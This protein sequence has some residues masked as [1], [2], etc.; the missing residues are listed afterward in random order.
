[1]KEDYK[2]LLALNM[3]GL[4][5]SL[6]D[7][8]ERLLRPGREFAQASFCRITTVLLLLAGIGLQGRVW[9]AFAQQESAPSF[10]VATIKPAPPF[11]LEKMQSASF[12]LSASKGPRPISN[13]YR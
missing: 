13:S 2:P 8:V 3:F 12:T 11:S 9:V 4:G 5:S 6:G 10:E 1:M 7:R